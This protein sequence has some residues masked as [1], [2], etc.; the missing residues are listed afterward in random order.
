MLFLKQ[1]TVKAMSAKGY[2][3][4]GDCVS[5]RYLNND[6]RGRRELSRIQNPRGLLDREHKFQS[7]RSAA[8]MGQPQSQD[9]NV[10]SASRFLVL[11]SRYRVVERLSKIRLD[12][13]RSVDEISQSSLSP[14]NRK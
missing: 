14:L 4:F 10:R 5:V 7:M 13:P 3:R 11:Q 12:Q 2:E 6:C 8:P 1:G 9:P